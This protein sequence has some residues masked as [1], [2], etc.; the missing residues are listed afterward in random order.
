MIYIVFTTEA[1]IGHVFGE[2]QHALE[3]I[4]RGIKWHRIEVWNQAKN[5]LSGLHYR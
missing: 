5:K 4:G 1:A 3:F 2:L